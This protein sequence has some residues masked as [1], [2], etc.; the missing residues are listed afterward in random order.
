MP[1]HP[2]E[3]AKLLGKK[4]NEHNV[5]CWLVNTG[6]T[7]GPYGIGH[8][9]SIKHTRALLNAALEGKLDKVEYTID[10]FFGFAIP[11]QC[12]GVPEEILMPKNSWKNK[13]VYEKKAKELS[14]EFKEKFSSDSTECFVCRK[15]RFSD[16]LLNN[17]SKSE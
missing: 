12:P 11:Q 10:P 17:F 2:S 14:E 9:I 16:P 3:Y 5:K 6:W 13:E 15:T 1:L 8:R 7:G 4:I